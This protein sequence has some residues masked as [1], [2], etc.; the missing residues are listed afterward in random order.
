MTTPA[1]LQALA[2]QRGSEAPGLDRSTSE[3]RRSDET[4]CAFLDAEGGM[5]LLGVRPYGKPAG[6]EIPAASDDSGRPESGRHGA[7]SRMTAATGCE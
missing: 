2:A 1:A 3:P 5:L 6:P 4:L 7:G